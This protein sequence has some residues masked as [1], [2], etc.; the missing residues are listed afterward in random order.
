MP[1]LAGTCSV[2]VSPVECSTSGFDGEMTS[3]I[4][5]NVW[6]GSAYSFCVSHEGLLRAVRTWNVDIIS[7]PGLWQSLVRCIWRLR[8][9]NWNFPEMT[10]GQFSIFFVL[11]GATAGTCSCV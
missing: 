5:R 3:C 11:L 9:M 2:S 10:S 7:R 8:R 4:W 6:F 1:Y